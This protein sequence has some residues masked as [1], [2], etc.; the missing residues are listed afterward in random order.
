MPTSDRYHDYLISQLK[1]L[2]YAAVY[3]ETY[4]E[5]DEE[6]DGTEAQLLALALADVAEALVEQKMPP[7]LA[8]KH[9]KEL[10]E[11]MSKSGTDA[12]YSLARW[13]EALG[14]KLTVVP[15]QKES[16]NQTQVELET[17]TKVNQS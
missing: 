15:D 11:I 12:I 14:L 8:K 10:D 9:R 5:E 16:N 4:L 6:T 3:L 1:D 2:S 7:E 13:L 17:T